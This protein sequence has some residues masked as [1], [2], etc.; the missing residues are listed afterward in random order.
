MG[1]SSNSKVFNMDPELGL[2]VR[3]TMEIHKEECQISTRDQDQNHQLMKLKQLTVQERDHKEEP[4]PPFTLKVEIPS[5]HDDDS[6]E[7]F[8]TPTSSDHK[9][10]AI[11]E[12]PGAPKKTKSRPATKR[13]ASCRRRIAL[14]FSMELEPLFP[15]SSVVDLGGGFINNKRVKRCTGTESKTWA[16]KGEP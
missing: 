13:K 4:L 12:C 6:E 11:L 8:K 14:D 16:L 9:I 7:G 1:M 5:T 10:P 2:S 3:S 15:T